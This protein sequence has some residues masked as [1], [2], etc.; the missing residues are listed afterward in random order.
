M[1]QWSDRSLD[2]SLKQLGQL[3]DCG[4]D[5]LDVVAL[6]HGVGQRPQR[7]DRR[8]LAVAA[9]ILMIV[10]VSTLLAVTPTRNAI[11]DWFGIGRTEIE[12]PIP[13][14]GANPLPL[15]DQ[16]LEVGSPSIDTSAAESVLGRPVPQVPSLQVDDLRTPP[17]GGVLVLYA[18]GTTL[19]IQVQSLPG[20]GLRK[21]SGL[22]GSVTWLDDL[23][24]GGALVSGPHTLVT[25]GRELRSESVVLWTANGMEL[26]L[27]GD[28]SDAELIELARSVDF[29]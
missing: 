13:G 9:A 3:L 14:D 29:G 22:T 26:R 25:P 5:D 16:S 6:V 11:A 17:E 28:L 10:T 1:S 18:D 8:V 23:G 21:K 2:V 20:P 19:W 15:P 24:D 27:E 4:T 7:P 12:V